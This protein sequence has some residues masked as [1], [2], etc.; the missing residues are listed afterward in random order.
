LAFLV[1]TSSWGIST[2]A[3]ERPLSQ[4]SYETGMQQAVT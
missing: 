1:F 3:A 4:L 2:N